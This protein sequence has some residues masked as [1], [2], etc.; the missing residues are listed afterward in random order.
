MYTPAAEVLAGRPVEPEVPVLVSFEWKGQQL[1]SWGILQG[2][3]PKEVILTKSTVPIRV[4]PE[5][6]ER[7]TYRTEPPSLAADLLGAALAFALVPLALLAAVF[8]RRAVLRT[9]Q[10]G[11]AAEA[12]VVARHGTALAPGTR[13]LKC[14]AAPRTDESG[15]AEGNGAPASGSRVHTVY[16]PLRHS[17][18]GESLLRVIVPPGGR[19]RPLS[20]AWFES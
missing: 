7:W 16:V 19:G 20:V 17:E 4:H 12:V 6:P 3:R 5:D 9:W 10:D 18:A 15:E 14:S 11:T 1:R 8:L 2:R 13:A